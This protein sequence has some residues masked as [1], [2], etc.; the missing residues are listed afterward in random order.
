MG[1]ALSCFRMKTY[2]PAFL[3]LVA[4]TLTTSVPV[5]EKRAAQQQG[6]SRIFGLD[7]GETAAGAGF[8]YGLSFLLNRL[9]GAGCRGRNNRNF[10][11]G[12]G[13]GFAFGS[14]TGAGC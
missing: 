1:L 4:L 7:L 6:Q 9:T 2:I 12:A 3:F 14:F 10:G 5:L 8:G 11:T 13:L